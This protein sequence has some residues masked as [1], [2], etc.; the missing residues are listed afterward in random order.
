MSEELRHYKVLDEIPET[1]SNE[2]IERQWQHIETSLT[3]LRNMHIE[4]A[5]MEFWAR[6]EMIMKGMR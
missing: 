4:R 6:F 3:I 2:E 5:N 1:Y